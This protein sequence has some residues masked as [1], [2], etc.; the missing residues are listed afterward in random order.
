MKLITKP[1][2][3]TTIKLTYIILYKKSKKLNIYI[4]I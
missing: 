2:H 1:Q 3:F 4:N